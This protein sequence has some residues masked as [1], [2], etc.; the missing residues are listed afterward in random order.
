MLH[1]A[2]VGLAGWGGWKLAR[3]V[4]PDPVAAIVVVATCAATPYL[5]AS[6]Q[7][8]RSEYLAGA[9]YPLHLA[10]LHAHLSGRLCVEHSGG[11]TGFRGDPRAGLGCAGHRDAGLRGGLGGRRRWRRR[12]H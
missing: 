3:R 6:A 12:W 10:F 5:M 9:W 2:T 8:G 4:I 1:V 7:L 11:G